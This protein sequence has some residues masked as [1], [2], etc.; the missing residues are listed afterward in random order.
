MHAVIMTQSAADMT[1][2]A[3]VLVKEGLW[4]ATWHPHLFQSCVLVYK[5]YIETLHVILVK[6]GFVV[7]MKCNNGSHIVLLKDP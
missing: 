2:L 4:M 6:R 3:I 5:L 7:D 1:S